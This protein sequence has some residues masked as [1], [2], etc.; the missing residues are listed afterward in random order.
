MRIIADLHIHSKYSRAT[1]DKMNMREL[2]RYAR[3]KGLNLLGTGDFTHPIWL[4]ELKENLIEDNGIYK[5]QSGFKYVL[6]VEVSNI[7]VQDKAQRKIHNVL[8]APSFEIVDQINE[9]LGKHGD[10]K[11]DGRPIFQGM[12]CIELVE[13]LMSISKQI[14]ITPAHVWTPWYGLF[15]SKSGFDSVEECFKDQTK[16]I[17]ALETGL[18]SDPPMNWRVSSLDRYCL[19]SNSDCHSPWPW[20]IGREANVFDLEKITYKEIT[21]AIKNK[22]NKKFLFTIEVDPAY[23]KY[24]FDGHRKCKISMSP[25]DAIKHNNLCP[26]CKKPLTIGVEHR[27]EELA[28]R[29]EGFNPENPI[30]FKRILP[31]TEIIANLLGI[32]DLY[33]KKV[34]EMYNKLIKAFE[35]EFNILLNVSKEDLTKVTKERIAEAVIKNREGEIEVEPGYDGEYGKP[36]FD[37]EAKNSVYKSSQKTLGQF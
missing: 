22:D 7:Y 25:K 10:L 32:S 33:S 9:F 6:S 35:N 29:P 19:V 15:G 36:I 23:G 28:D 14:M 34:W 11:A 18:S 5:T 27:V 12:N 17:Y 24:H 37:S 30:D 1:S 2:E 21:E 4:K 8:W 26:K 31:L 3:I 20:R 13:G 16:H